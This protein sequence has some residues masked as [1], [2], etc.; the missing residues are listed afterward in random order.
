MSRP[1]IMT[2][3]LLPSVFLVAV[4]AP[5]PAA[6]AGSGCTAPRSYCTAAP[7][8]VHPTGSFLSH[9]GSTSV[10][11]D[12]FALVAVHLPADEVAVFFCG[13]TRLEVPFGDGFRCVG[14]PA[15][16][17]GPEDTGPSGVVVRELDVAA[18][19]GPGAAFSPGSTWHFQLWYADPRGR[20]GSGFNLS[21]GLEVRWCP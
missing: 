3:R 20:G 15:W 16:R 7:N 12:D 1:P 5:A 10:G 13:P 11:W 2:G 19:P 9:Q 8:S 6:P 17:L 14:A 4:L 21:D 18:G